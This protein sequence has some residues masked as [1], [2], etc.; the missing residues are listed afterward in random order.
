VESGPDAKPTIE[1]LEDER[2]R[3]QELERNLAA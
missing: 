3:L 2:R 1:A